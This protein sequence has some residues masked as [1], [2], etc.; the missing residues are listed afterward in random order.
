[1]AIKDG[2]PAFPQPLMRTESGEVLTPDGWG[3]GTGLSLRDY[4]AGQALAGL[5]ANPN[6]VVANPN[7][8]WSLCNMDDR[9]LADTTYSLADVL[10]AQ[11]EQAVAKAGR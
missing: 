8:G 10:L 7:C 4:F 3:Y 2:G 11:R 9:G 5:L 6:V 1:M